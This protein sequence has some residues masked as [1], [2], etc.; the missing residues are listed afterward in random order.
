MQQMHSRK[1][2]VNYLK[3]SNNDTFGVICCC[4]NGAVSP[5]DDI[6]PLEWVNIEMWEF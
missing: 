3:K 6:Q 5:K 4:N 1:N 2:E